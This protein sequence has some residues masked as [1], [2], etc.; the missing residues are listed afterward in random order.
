MSA[1]VEVF[2]PEDAERYIADLTKRE[3]VWPGHLVGFVDAW[4]REIETGE[5]AWE[6]HQKNL[7][8]DFGR[9]FWM[10]QRFGGIQVFTSPCV[11]DPDVAMNHLVDDGG[12]SSGQ[13]STTAGGISGTYDAPTL[14]RTY[15]HNFTTPP[16]AN[17]SIGAIGLS[18]VQRST[19][20]GALGVVAVTRLSPAKVQT[21]TQTVEVQ[22][23]ITYIPV[24]Y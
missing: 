8:T 16:A 21:P 9:R 2:S 12:T 11:E 20:L 24:S 10:L 18:T 1:Q 15:T 23:R 17:R 4:C 5:V 7:I 6:L 14:T 19:T 22:Y 13:S 3:G